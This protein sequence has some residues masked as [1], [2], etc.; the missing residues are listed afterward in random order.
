VI[1]PGTYA[2]TLSL[3][4]PEGVAKVTTKPL[5]VTKTHLPYRVQDLFTVAAGDQQGLAV[6]AGTFYIGFDNGDGTARI[7]EYNPSGVRT[8]S[9]GPLAIG[10]AAELSYSTTTGMLYAANGGATNATSVWAIDPATGAVKDTVDLS[11]LGNNGMVAVDDAGGRLLVFA[12]SSGAYT[13]TAVSL[14]TTPAPV[15]ANGAPTGPPT[16]TMSTPVPIAITGVPQGIEVVGTQLWVYTSLKN[17]NHVARYDLTQN[18]AL[19]SGDDL[20]NAGEGEG[21][22]VDSS[23]WMYVGAHTMNRVGVLRP[24]AD[25]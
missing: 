7:D 13:V 19:L 17:R 9:L 4:G 3:R 15:D 16:H 14:A 18:D 25:E 12:G 24:V 11:M 23:G 20:M 6:H 8:G 10:H 2:A 21:L 1:V 22:A 5:L